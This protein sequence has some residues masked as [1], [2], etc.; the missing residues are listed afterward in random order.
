MESLEYEVLQKIKFT[1]FCK[2]E[3]M[4]I[5]L[6]EQFAFDKTEEM[7]S[8]DCIKKAIDY[9]A[10]LGLNDDIGNSFEWSEKQNKWIKQFKK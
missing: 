2:N 9:G 6:L 7:Y 5:R 8:E 1:L 10:E 4:A 3:A